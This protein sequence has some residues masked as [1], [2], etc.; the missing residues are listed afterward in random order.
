[1]IRLRPALLLIP[2]LSCRGADTRTPATVT[3]AQFADLR[4]LS[5]SWSGTGSG[6][7]PFFERYAFVD[8]STIQ[9]HGYPDSTFGAPG[10]S[11]RITL[12]GGQVVSQSA[13]T[14]VATSID[15]VEVRFDHSEKPG[16]AFTFRRVSH[17]EWTAHIEWTGDKGAQ[18][19]TY[20][21][22]RVP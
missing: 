20:Q 13:S 10:D 21:M 19:I 12:R 5:G 17:T 3:P 14:W 1:M 18:T 11:S 6:V 16:N 22:T 8:D 15:S 2:L 4:W 7:K 9:M